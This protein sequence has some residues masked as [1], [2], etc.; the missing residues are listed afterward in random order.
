M[1]EKEGSNRHFREGYLIGRDFIKHIRQTQVLKMSRRE[2]RLLKRLLEQIVWPEEKLDRIIELLTSIN[3]RLAVAP[4]PPPPVGVVGIDDESIRKLAEKIAELGTA[5]LEKLPNRIDLIKIDTSD[6]T[7]VSLKRTGK[8]KPALALGFEVED[9]GGG[10]EYV[11][12]RGGFGKDARTAMTGDKF[13]IAFD[14]LLVTGS[15]NAGKAKLWYW[16]RE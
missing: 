1:E 8:I 11:I 2:D 6:T 9:V 4:P 10:F 16:W 14:D 15:G 13:N 7:Q 5:P 3:E 12:V